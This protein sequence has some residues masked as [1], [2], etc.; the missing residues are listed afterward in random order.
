MWLFTI[1]HIHRKYHTP[2][3]AMRPTGSSFGIYSFS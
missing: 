1:E 2:K 3:K